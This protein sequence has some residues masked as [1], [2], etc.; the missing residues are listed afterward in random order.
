MKYD[1]HTHTTFS[2]GEL[3]V[4]GNVN[5]A[6]ERGLDGIA[7]SDHDN[8]EA[9]KLI[10]NNKYPIPVIKGVELSTYYNNENVHILGYYLNNGQS[11]K[12]LED[13]L[14]DLREKRKTRTMKMIHL[15]EEQG[16]NITYEEVLKHAD[17]A[18]ARPHIAEAII[19][20]YPERNYTIQDVFD[21][22]IGNDK[23]AYVKTSD[24]QTV[25]AIKLLHDNNCLAVLAHPLLI[26]KQDY[27]ELLNLDID[28][29]ECYYPYE[30]KDY[31][32]VLE[33][34]R[35]R[36][37]IITGGSDFHGPIVRNTMGK[38]YLEGEEL[39][40]FLRKINK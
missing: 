40:T 33:E 4:E 27:K 7:I 3:T 29:V 20:K 18:I 26:K 8:L 38:A 19:E 15:L 30:D 22:Y 31:Q 9:W 5:L 12:K 17:G 32:E 1:L 16:I 34:A 21:L 24:F 23:P 39:N 36:N 14:T 35:K 37:L 13:F 6:V 11:Y 25:D 10:D 28:G 2:D